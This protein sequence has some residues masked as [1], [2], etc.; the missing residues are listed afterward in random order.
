MVDIEQGE[1]ETVLSNRD[2]MCSSNNDSGGSGL[3]I[4]RFKAASFLSGIALDNESQ[5]QCNTG[6]SLR[7][8]GTS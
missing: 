1:I 8:D 5:G 7:R 2:D 3:S 6:G 4:G